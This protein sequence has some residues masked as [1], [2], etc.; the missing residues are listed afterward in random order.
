LKPD[1]HELLNL[2]TTPVHTFAFQLHPIESSGMLCTP[3]LLW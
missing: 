1:C 2:F 3:E